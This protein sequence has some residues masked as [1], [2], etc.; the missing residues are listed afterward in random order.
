[1]SAAESA[2][3]PRIALSCT[4]GE[5]SRVAEHAPQST[6]VDMLVNASQQGRAPAC[7]PSAD[8]NSRG[9]GE[10]LRVQAYL[11]P[12]VLCVDAMTRTV[13]HS[14]L[15]GAHSHDGLARWKVVVS[16]PAS[17]AGHERFCPCVCSPTAVRQPSP[18]RGHGPAGL[19][20]SHRAA[21][22]CL[23]HG[24]NATTLSMGTHRPEHDEAPCGG[25]GEL[26]V[27]CTAASARAGEREPSCCAD[28]GT[29]GTVGQCQGL[30]SGK[31]RKT[32]IGI[33]GCVS[34]QCNPVAQPGA[35]ARVQ[36]PEE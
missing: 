28:S 16:R 36:F 33:Q 32:A 26:L 4:C 7:Q 11:C 3:S 14:G 5:C 21:T 22:R 19:R 9:T 17:G 30:L 29:V 18:L 12:V 10:S 8:P 31:G 13:E 23:R 15:G 1:M 27:G 20:F 2:G 25:A 35:P 34:D 24:S 6:M